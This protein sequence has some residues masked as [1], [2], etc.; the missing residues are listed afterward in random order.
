MREKLAE[1]HFEVPAELVD[2]K[3]TNYLAPPPPPQQ[4]QAALKENDS[5]TSLKPKSK[6]SVMS[7][8]ENKS[9]SSSV[10]SSNTQGMPPRVGGR[11]RGRT[12]SAVVSSKV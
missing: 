12:D 10:V 2:D 7:R 6:T 5:R 8:D 3:L 1:H 11:V 9:T 4:Q